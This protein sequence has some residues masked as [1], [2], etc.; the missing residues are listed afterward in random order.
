M[1]LTPFVGA[2]ITTYGYD[3]ADRLISEST[4]LPAGGNN[5]ISY[6]WDGNGNLAQ[7]TEG[8]NTT[9]YRWDAN[10]R[11]I[12]IRTGST[13]AQAQAANPSVAY[14]YDASGNR[15]K[16]SVNSA[17]SPGATSATSYLI[18]SNHSYAQVALEST[19]NT[20]SGGTGTA[21]VNS[22]AYVWG[23]G[24]IRQT[25]VSAASGVATN[26]FGSTQASEDL[27][28]LSGH[29]GTSLGAVDANG[30]VA[31]QTS[32]DA[33]GNLAQTSN[34]KQNHLYTGEYWDQD[35][36]LTYLRARWYDAKMG[37]FISAD[38]FEGRQQDPRSLNR[39]A[40]AHNDPVHMS[41][42]TGGF[43]MGEVGAGM[44][45]MANLATTAINV[46]DIASLLFGGD[47][48]SERSG[49]WDAVMQMGVSAI[50]GMIGATSQG[51]ISAG[52]SLTAPIEG[53]HT[54]PVY[55]CGAGKQNLVR[56]E[57]SV[58]KK[59]HRDLL[60]T[61]AIVQGLGFAADKLFF[62]TRII[63]GQ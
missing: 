56:I 15:I 8:S 38:P 40:Y 62:K 1:S 43:S 3:A 48:N 35:S 4:S 52:S 63:T 16:K 29:L 42:P 14:A 25:K 27:F 49:I 58:H 50:G 2:T 37:R 5:S 30:N 59:I 17:A 33:F 23:A 60:T 39:Y 19:V 12:D 6:S 13:A 61:Y 51:N 24:L 44:N 45:A 57:R 47:D 36:Q 34:L 55:L 28:P 41:D 11:L 9:L 7:K 18:D 32:A 46:I 10:N 53:H 21:T 26:V 54:I 31:E 20:P 22:T